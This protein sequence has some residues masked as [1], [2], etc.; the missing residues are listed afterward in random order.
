[1]CVVTSTSEYVE[2]LSF[3]PNSVSVKR[4]EA[5]VEV[6]INTLE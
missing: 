2:F 6:T 3:N 4:L 1:M 5:G